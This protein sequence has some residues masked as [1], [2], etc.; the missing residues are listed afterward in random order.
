[1]RL[2]IEDRQ[3]VAMML[4][5]HIESGWAEP[6]ARTA[7]S[8]IQRSKHGFADLTSEEVEALLNVYRSFTEDLY[9]T[10]LEETQTGVPSSIQSR[11]RVHG[12]TEY[13]R[14]LDLE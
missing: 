12:P 6:S 13:P 4:Q 14:E 11:R 3:K 7:L 9:W 8:K 10:P 2:Y 1:M 5:Q